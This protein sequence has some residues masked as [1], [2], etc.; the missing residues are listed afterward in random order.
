MQYL[1]RKMT[2]SI[3]TVLV[4]GAAGGIGGETAHALA[5]HG[6]KIR[7]LAR[8]GRPSEAATMWDWIKGD[9]LD[10]ASVVAAA[11]GA[12]AI[13]HAVNPRGYRNWSTLV[14]PMIENTIAAAKASG[15]RI[16]LPG[17]IYNYGPD[18]FP[19][20][21]EDSPQRATTHKGR[22]RI[23]LEQRLVEAAREGVRSLIV[24]LGDFFGPKPGNNWFSQAFVKPGTHITSITNPGSKG[25]GHSWAYLPDAGEAFAQLMDRESELADFERFH[26]RGHWDVDGTEMIKAIRK[27]AGDEK[28][29]VKSLP[30]LIFKLASP[31]NET[32]RELYA[33]RPLWRTPIQLDN[34]KLVHFLGKEPHTPLQAA[35]ETTLRGMSCL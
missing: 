33:T 26:F 34:S 23:A 1:E 31:F 25:I 24:R 19:V 35:A 32:M 28:I 16:L 7:A 12:D 17:T 10:Q 8:N 6:W 27:A 30:W 3:R 29:P 13:V 11:R 20:L 21:R 9:A 4:L 2:K 15:A 22:I 5:R 18:A 14:L